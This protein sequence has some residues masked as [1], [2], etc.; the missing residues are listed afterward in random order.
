M[1]HYIVAVISD[2]GDDYDDLLEP[3]DEENEDY[4]MFHAVD[5]K[6]AEN[7]KRSY[8]V[9]AMSYGSDPPMFD[10]YLEEHGYIIKD[11]KI[12]YF[13]NENAKW[14]WYTLDA[15]NGFFTHKDGVND[16]E[17]LSDYVFNTADKLKP[18][19][20]KEEEHEWKL[21]TGQEEPAN[22]AERS[23]SIYSTEY[24]RERYPTFEDYLIQY[25]TDAPYAYVTPDGEWHAPGTV[26]YFGLS[27]ETP[28]SY[29]KYVKEWISY[30]KEHPDKYVSFVDC[31][32]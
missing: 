1:S 29:K 30:V 18:E 12:G 27:D 21:L 6:T 23:M 7:L 15:K 32:I 26:G 10:E 19:E 9:D 2:T 4:Y 20:L 31:H 14:D 13:C 24:M 17:K 3:Y 16:P 25:H 11:D 8:D 28:E 22:D 5:E